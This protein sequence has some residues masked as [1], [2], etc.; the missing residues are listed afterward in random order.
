M[1]MCMLARGSLSFVPKK[2]WSPR[3]Q[4]LYDTNGKFFETKFS[5]WRMRGSV[6]R[7]LSDATTGVSVRREA[8]SFSL[9]YFAIA[10]HILELSTKNSIRVDP[11]R[12]G[13][14]PPVSLVYQNARF[15]SLVESRYFCGRAITP[16][17]LLS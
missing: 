9:S 17:K 1:L 2:S 13:E 14:L 11:V 3:A 16:G 12:S 6:A 15:P 7:I 10:T 8:H 4:P 5:R